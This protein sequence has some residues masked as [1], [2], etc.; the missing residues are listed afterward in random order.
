MKKD[1]YVDIEE[2]IL[3]R[4]KFGVV[5]VMDASL[6]EEIKI[7]DPL[8][9]FVSNSIA[10]KLKGFVYGIDIGKKEST[11]Y[12]EEVKYPSN[13]WEAFRERFFPNFW[14]RKFPI[15]YN[16]IPTE[17][18]V[19]QDFKNICPHIPKSP[20]NEHIYFL[21]NEKDWIDKIDKKGNKIK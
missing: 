9:D 2:I 14:K 12:G 1:K 15:I 21:K 6:L 11:Y 3:Q 8:F 5:E 20:L 16:E 13:W 19:Y 10:I 17:V 4:I 7:S 18:T